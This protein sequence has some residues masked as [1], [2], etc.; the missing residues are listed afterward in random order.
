M[1]KS[2]E[3]ESS[4]VKRGRRVFNELCRNGEKTNKTKVARLAKFAKSN[5]F[6]DKSGVYKNAA[7]QSLAEDIETLSEKG[8]KGQVRNKLDEVRLAR[9]DN[10]RKYNAQVKNNTEILGLKVEWEHEKNH[11]KQQFDIISME[12]SKLRVQV[13]SYQKAFDQQASKKTISSNISML[14][15]VVISPD[16]E[17]LRING[18]GYAYGDS[19][20]QRAAHRAA[21][22][23]LALSLS[24]TKVPIRL[25]VLLGRPASGKSF[26]VVHHKPPHDRFPVYYDATNADA[27]ERMDI[28]DI[29]ATNN[30]CV[31]CFVYM[32]TTVATCIRQ[33]D[34]RPKK[35]ISDHVIEGFNIEEPRLDE[36]FD[37]LIIVRKA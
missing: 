35:G 27:G 12:N 18:G 23:K 31:V 20:I 25:Y 9:D 7:W 21:Q 22:A 2:I 15:Q 16:E 3:L 13:R 32:D 14:H 24:E 11:Y 4:A 29:A 1:S 17:M 8:T 33:N 34:L 30:D 6:S 19:R 26:W 28:L 37:E 10:I 36:L 5:L